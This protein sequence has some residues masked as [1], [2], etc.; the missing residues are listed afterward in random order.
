MIQQ[1]FGDGADGWVGM[2]VFGSAD[3]GMGQHGWV[4]LLVRPQGVYALAPA[5]QQA[6]AEETLAVWC[7]M[8]GSLGWHGLK[9]RITLYLL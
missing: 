7:S 4:L 6:V 8:A 9:V 2:Y 5:K 1:G 3:V